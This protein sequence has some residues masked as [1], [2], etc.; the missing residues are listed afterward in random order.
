MLSVGDTQ[1][2]SASSSS[3]QEPA[4]LNSSSAV[5]QAQGSAP[6]QRSETGP[7]PCANPGKI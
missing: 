1:P 4:T 5:G 3:S 2:R 6:A 7:V